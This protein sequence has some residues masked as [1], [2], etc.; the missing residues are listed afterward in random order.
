MTNRRSPFFTELAV[1][2]RD[3][4]DVAR[5][6]RPDLDARDSFEA[7]RVLVPLDDLAL[8]RLADRDAGRRRR[9]FL[10]GIGLALASADRS[11]RAPARARLRA[12][13]RR[14][15]GHRTSA[16][17]CT[18]LTAAAPSSTPIQHRRL[19]AKTAPPFT[20]TPRLEG[21]GQAAT[22]LAVAAAF[23]PLAAID[24]PART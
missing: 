11:P 21:P 10:L 4:V 12:P 13:A 5:H 2:E 20:L 19:N 3:L 9:G 14:L 22:V 24:V 1:G 8:D 15:G 23:A 6:P 17:A 18:P 16:Y 7:A